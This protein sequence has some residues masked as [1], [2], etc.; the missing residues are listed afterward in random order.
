VLG[1]RRT[2]EDRRRR[3]VEAGVPQEQ[4]D[5]LHAPIG[6]D[7]GGHS[8]QETAI[9]IPAEIIAVRT[10]GAGASLSSVATPIHA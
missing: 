5:R 3:L 4:L 7:L 8:V 1:S 2:C 9:S 10:R 6:L